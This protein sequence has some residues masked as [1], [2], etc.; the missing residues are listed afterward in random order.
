MEVSWQLD[1]NW[2]PGFLFRLESFGVP[3]GATRR[4]SLHGWKKGSSF[5]LISKEVR[6]CRAIILDVKPSVKSR[7]DREPPQCSRLPSG[8]LRNLPS[9]GHGGEVSDS[10][11]LALIYIESPTQDGLT[12]SVDKKTM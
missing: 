11:S 12:Y 7:E 3:H 10:S 1:P 8:Y 9:P 2:G 6:F 4:G 5:L